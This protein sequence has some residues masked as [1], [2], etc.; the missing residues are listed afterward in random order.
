MASYKTVILMAAAVCSV[1]AVASQDP[2]A[3]LGWLAPSKSVSKKAP[4]KQKV[5]V[6]Q[7]IICKAATPCYAV[8]DDKL[9]YVNDVVSGYKVKSI[10]QEKV[11][12]IK[13]SV[14]Y[15]LTLFSTDIKN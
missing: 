5:P 10:T 15:P 7:S 2:T 9:A 4:K 8:L 12:V 13:G 1:K 11:V 3:P 14:T 6:L